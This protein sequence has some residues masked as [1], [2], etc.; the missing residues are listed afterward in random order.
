MGAVTVALLVAV[1][2]V[3]GIGVSAGAVRRWFGNERTSVRDYHQ[4]LETLRHLSD[5]RAAVEAS[6]RAPT[7]PRASTASPQAGNGT[8]P[9]AELASPSS[10][11]ADERPGARAGAGSRRPS[12]ARRSTLLASSAPTAQ[13]AP[14][15]ADRSGP[16][17][18]SVPVQEPV[19][20]ER[21]DAWDA[22]EVRRV[23]ETPV[24]GVTGD[25]PHA[26]RV[27][28]ADAVREL[29]AARNLHGPRS[30][31]PTMPFPG[32]A[33]RGPLLW[34]V[35][36]VV[37]IGAVTAAVL[38]SGPSH[39]SGTPTASAH[40]SATGVH[41]TTAPPART[42][43]RHGSSSSTGSSSGHSASGGLEL[44]TSSSSAATYRVPSVPYTLT[45]NATGACWVEATNS[46]T[47]QVLWTGTLHAG[48]AQS[49]PASS[50]VVLRLGDA[51]NVALAVSG[52]A[53]HLPPGSSTTIDLTFLPA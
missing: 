8:R 11:A 38:A 31:H 29:A 22:D 45:L 9:A 2:V 27:S 26:H 19:E 49:V 32:R 41:R 4:T 28:A 47:G 34:T 25:L 14:V 42:A 37:V 16:P 35:A 51:L 36:A 10:E 1:L 15:L 20:V 46:S 44:V 3:V 24:A 53:V 43:A 48:D 33:E 17:A 50:E 13:R 18:I 40:S 5:R 12:K 39:G 52:Q 6:V 30:Q 23:S 7:S 21:A